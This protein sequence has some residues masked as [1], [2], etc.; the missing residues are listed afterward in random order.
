MMGSAGQPGLLSRIDKTLTTFPLAAHIIMCKEEGTMWKKNTVWL[1]I[2]PLTSLLLSPGCATLIRKKMQRIPVTSAPVGA[3]VIINGVEQGATPLEV[4]LTRKQKGQVIRIESP[5]YNPYEIQL[6]RRASLI[7]DL[8][9]AV[10][11]IALC[12]PII[13]AYAASD[14]DIKEFVFV[15]PLLAA[16]V[17]ALPV[18]VDRIS[19]K[20]FEF[21]PKNL[22][23]TL[24][25]ADG[26]PRVDTIVIEAEDFKN[27]KWIRVHRD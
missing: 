15:A 4:W 1:L 8:G 12:V 24:T 19:K 5:G 2:L 25:K 11:G 18:S 10:I 7:T 23:V 27:I 26:T 20:S 3:T 17:I 13:N 21:R 16:G 6:K 22:T 14:P 9:N